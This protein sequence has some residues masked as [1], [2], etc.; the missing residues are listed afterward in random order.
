[1][2]LLVT[3]QRD[4]KVFGTVC[5]H[6]QLPYT[7]PDLMGT[8]MFMSKAKELC[9]ELVVFQYDFKQYEIVSEQVC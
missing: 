5:L 1:M 8:G 3:T 6:P 4:T 7:L 2:S 9:P